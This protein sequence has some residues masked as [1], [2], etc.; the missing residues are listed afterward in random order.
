MTQSALRK[1]LTR[2]IQRRFGLA[3]GTPAGWS[4]GPPDFI[5]I[6]AQRAG[7][8]WWYGMICDHPAVEPAPAGKELHFFDR[9]HR[10]NLTDKDIDAYHR[11]LPRPPGKLTGEW[12]PRYMRDPW[13]MGMLRRAAPEAKLLIMLRD[14]WARFLSGVSH[15]SRLLDESSRISRLRRRDIEGM[16]VV[17]QIARS[18]YST[19]LKRVLEHFERS[20]VLILQYEQCCRD[21]AQQLR[22]TYD[23][24]GVEPVGH[25]PQ[26]PTKREGRSSPEPPTSDHLQAAATS[27]L[28]EDAKELLEIAPEIDLSLWPSV[29]DAGDA[30]SLRGDPAHSIQPLTSRPSS[31]SSS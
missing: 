20:Q 1:K 28:I 23:F 25:W 17:D 31:S 21:P 13:T 5:G 24:L 6:G 22:R 4:V 15:E 19:Q 26:T 11:L 16:I 18:C 8:K 14:P 29:Q 10:H 12:T 2:R 30:P 27:R 7:T 3:P 9:F